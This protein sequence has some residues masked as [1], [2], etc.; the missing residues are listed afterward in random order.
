[1]QMHRHGGFTLIEVLVALFVLAV[2]VAG[3][4]AAQL[5]AQRTRQHAA[6]TSEAAQLAA[7][8][9]A[10]MQANPS[11]STLPA[12][13][14]PYIGFDYAAGGAE[15]PADGVPCFGA[16]GCDAVGLAAFDLHETRL[17]VHGR[18]PGGRIAVCRDG[19]PWDGAGQRYR[20]ECSDDPHAPV[21]IKIGWHG[22]A[23]G[24]AFVAMVAR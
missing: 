22:S 14:N 10:R 15:P 3:A 7:S 21:A 19:A 23:D 2:G 20:W 4:G 5:A 24:P 1:M 13:A 11:V 6:L 16:G 12:G 8:L 17:A 9:A 18:F